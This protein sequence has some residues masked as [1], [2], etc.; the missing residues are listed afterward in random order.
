M[1]EGVLNEEIEG[2]REG[3]MRKISESGSSEVHKEEVKTA[4]KQVGL[5][6][7]PVDVW[8]S[9]REGSRL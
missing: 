5:D 9:R 1:M 2:E 3:Q 7:I 4:E 6:D 8:R